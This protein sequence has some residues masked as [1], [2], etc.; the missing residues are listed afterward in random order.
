M[1]KPEY[2][3]DYHLSLDNPY[4]LRT[5]VQWLLVLSLGVIVGLIVLGMIQSED[6]GIRIGG[7]VIG[8]AFI[9]LMV[10]SAFVW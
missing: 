9:A 4:K 6:E 10:I 8:F 5:P 2:N 1:K 3:P 7:Y